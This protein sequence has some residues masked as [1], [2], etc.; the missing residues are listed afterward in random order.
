MMR[1]ILW[2]IVFQEPWL[3][4]AVVEV[5]QGSLELLTVFLKNGVRGDLHRAVL[6]RLCWRVSRLY[7][8]TSTGAECKFGYALG[9]LRFAFPMTQIQKVL[10]PGDSLRW[11]GVGSATVLRLV[12]PVLQRYCRA[13]LAAARE[14]WVTSLRFCFERPK[15]RSVSLPTGVESIGKIIENNGFGN[16]QQLPFP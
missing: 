14:K 5:L 10:L 3:G 7:L 2:I 16:V 1:P 13:G 9:W 12:V 8:L 6:R 4:K 11:Q 15:R